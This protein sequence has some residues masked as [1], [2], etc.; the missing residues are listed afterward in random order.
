MRR[1]LSRKCVTRKR[2]STR[3]EDG[4]GRE[5]RPNGELGRATGDRSREW[6]RAKGLDEHDIPTL[7]MCPLC[8]ITL[9]TLCCRR[10]S[11]DIP[12]GFK[13]FA[14]YMAFFRHISS[15]FPNKIR[16]ELQHSASMDLVL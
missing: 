8:K 7:P 15:S 6:V 13:V 3:C 1:P 9:V 2:S 11:S 12:R 16:I 14:V 5:E 4:R 10:K